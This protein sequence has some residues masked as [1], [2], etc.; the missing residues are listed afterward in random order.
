M[1]F[2]VSIHNFA[3]FADV[4]R[5]ATLAKEA[6]DTGWDGFFLWDHIHRVGATEPMVDPWIALAAMALATDR[7]KIG[8]MVTPVARR[9]P[10]KLARE[11]VTIDQLSGGRLILGVGLG[12]PPEHEFTQLGEDADDR[13]RATKLDE[14][15]DVLARLWSG[16]PFSYRGEHY[17][18]DDVTFLP[19]PVNGTIPIWIAGVWPA[20]A[21][22]R[23][24]AR[25][26]GVAPT[27]AGGQPGQIILLPPDELR[28]V[29]SYTLE[30]RSSNAPFEV[31]SS[32]VFPPDRGAARDMVEAHAAAGATWM[33]SWQPNPEALSV[34]LRAG[35]P[36]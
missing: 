17:R 10:W 21:P 35:P 2:A 32:V 25:Y 7:L 16:A 34:H 36:V 4:R 11:T 12:G 30:H 26:D 31:N 27:K 15:L 18:L 8:T 23:R 1:K 9:R 24:A 29:L 28:E 22:F 5:L 6:E 19:R 33:Q 20:K 14:G 3:E 13:V